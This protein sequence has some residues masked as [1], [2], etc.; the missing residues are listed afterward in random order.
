VLTEL[1]VVLCLDFLS[2]AFAG[3]LARWTFGRATPGAE[4]RRLVNAAAR[5]AEA[6]LLREG[7]LVA[8]GVGFSLLLVL[9]AHGYLLARHT[10]GTTP[11]SVLWPAFAALL[12]AATTIG[13]AYLTTE[14]G[15]HAS[16]R[17]GR[18]VHAGAP[19][20]TSL[21]LR[22]AGVSAL[23]AD[24]LGA[25][26]VAFLLG[27]L[28]LLGGG[29]VAASPAE[30]SLLLERAAAVLPGLGVGSVAAALVLGLGG[31]AYRISAS[32]A[33]V[34]AA[35]LGPTDPRNPSMVASLVGEHVGTG[36]RRAVDA[37]AAAMLANVAIV[38]LGVA[39]F[40][41]NQGAAGARAWAL[42]TLPLVVR[43]VGTVAS[44]VGLVAARSTE[45]ER[46]SMA[47][48]RGHATA[49]L[50]VI[51]GLAGAALWLI[52][53]PTSGWVVAAGA[54]GVVA[55]VA[56]TYAVR[57]TVDRRLSAVQDV[58]E[59][60]RTSQAVTFARGLGVGSRAI[61][62]PV[63]LLAASLGSGF[64]LGEHVGIAG[65]GLLGTATA[66]V[67]LLSTAG[68][69]LAVGLF[70]P[71]ACG[72]ASVAA[73][74]PDG[75]RPDVRAAVALDDAGFE[76]GRAADPYF[77]ALGS[78]AV[79]VT[80]LS[81]PLVVTT[82]LGA[83]PFGLS[84]SPI[85][86]SGLIGAA[87]VVVAAGLGLEIAAR[88]TRGTVAEVER[89]LRAFPRSRE[90][91][92]GVVQVPEGFTPSY[93]A[94]IDLA[95]RHS[96]EGLVA[97]AMVGL[98]APPVLGFGLR[99]LYRSSGLAAE[100]LTSFV[101]IAAATSLATALATDG[102]HSVLGAAQREIRPRGASAG[103]DASVAGHQI[104]TFIGDM[105]APAARLFAIAL[106]ASALVIAPLLSR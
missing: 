59:A 69:V 90:G 67:G 20:A 51:G 40:R 46:G 43:A 85:V 47:L 68:Y 29:S 82:E 48:L 70:G 88:A 45:S 55:G 21:A 106:A 94:L 16:L 42:V 61:W 105:F 17:A 56:T 81:I 39:A 27:L 19:H 93:K 91:D 80:G 10:P 18:A 26:S 100:G 4:A 15:L 36:V 66:L 92:G 49:S 14:V 73:L 78:G 75:S 62:L 30:T 7:K 3:L 101:V 87:L 31:A 13:V 1:G 102:A 32:V 97:P 28:Y 37:F 2:L 99:L 24:A 23:A 5:A 89:Q 35:G 79:V 103:V 38:T 76:G 53:G 44:G 60:A 8:A 12:G 52:G 41:A 104:G 72:A 34:G 57:R 63:L 9:G 64:Q 65:G 50:I 74:E 84:G 11:S 83:A 95:A 6:F 98:L 77:I 25:G 96:A 54:S 58:L 86:W 71:I 22:A 33:A